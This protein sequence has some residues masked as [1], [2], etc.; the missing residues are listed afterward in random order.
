MPARVDIAMVAKNLMQ[1]RGIEPSVVT[2]N[3]LIDVGG[4]WG[5]GGEGGETDT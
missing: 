1:A 4:K 2:Y 3:A 5:R